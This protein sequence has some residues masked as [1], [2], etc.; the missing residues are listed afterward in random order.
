MPQDI[1]LF[2]TSDFTHAKVFKA[3]REVEKL[4]ESE[5]EKDDLQS[6]F[7]RNTALFREIHETL[8][9][10]DPEDEDAS[11]D[12][13]V[14]KG[15]HHYKLQSLNNNYFY[16]LQSLHKEQRDARSQEEK[17]LIQAEIDKMNILT[18]NDMNAYADMV[19]TILNQ[20][21]YT[22]RHVLDNK[23]SDGREIVISSLV[24]SW[25]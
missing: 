12:H 19:K 11:S 18:P 14:F 5:Y 24:I 3:E 6:F 10:H 13:I 9:H 22:V 16:R 15:L 7:R 25:A 8:Y 4:F 20:R 23:K 17:K 1:S 21:G 2:F